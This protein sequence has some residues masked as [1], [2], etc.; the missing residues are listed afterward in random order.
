M[1]VIELMVL[2]AETPSA[3][4]RAG[5]PGDLPDVRD[6]GCEFDQHRGARNFLDPGCDH[7]GV[8]GDLADGA[9]HAALAHA[10]GAAEVEFEAVGAGVFAALNDVVPGF[11][12]RFDH[13]GRDDGVVRVALL[14]S[15]ISRRLTSRGRS[16]MSSML[17]RPIMRWPLS[18]R[19]NSASRR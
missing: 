4:P 18:R 5:R 9:A 2:M 11:A 8:F 14:T 13:E 16:V 7:L 1:P 3:P 10:V 12:L 17:L 6:V 15:A 19:R